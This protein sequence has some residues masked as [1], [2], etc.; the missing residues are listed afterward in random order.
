MTLAAGDGPGSQA[1][2]SQANNVLP[3][4]DQAMFL[5]LRGAGQDSVMQ[6]LWIYDHP[7]DFEVLERFQND[8]GRGWMARL[9]EPSPLP[10]GR[11]RWVSAP[12]PRSDLDVGSPPRA[13]NEFGAWADEQ[14]QLPLDPQSG[15]AWRLGVQ[16]FDDG[17]TAI[18]LV[19]SHCI[20]DG[21]AAIDSI[22]DA[23]NGKVRK[24]DYPP[25]GSRTTVR[26]LREDLLQTVR[27]GGETLRT[28][29]KAL[30]ML[31]RSRR[32]ASRPP[33]EKPLSDKPSRK[34]PAP[35]T[36]G[37]RLSLP[38]VE[39]VV[40]VE[41]WDARA[42][43]LGGNGLSLVAGFAGRLAQHLGRVRTPDGAVTLMIP[44]SE[45]DDIG[46]DTG[47]NVVSI[48]RVS[49]DP[50]PLTTDLSGARAAIRSAVQVARQTP[51][52]M[53][54]LMPL[55]PFVPKR[56]VA[57]MADLAF[58]FSADLPVS[59]SNLGEVPAAM[60]YIDG[61]AAQYLSFRGVD[62]DL[63]RELVERKRGLLTL[64]SGRIEGVVTTTVIGYQPGADNT[65]DALRGLVAQTLEEFNL[66]ATII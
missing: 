37:E 53:V 11:H 54:E 39:F 64:I 50:A 57:G 40:D 9:I 58:G 2:G 20:A 6:F 55:T 41:Q 16:P 42:E 15:P 59:C 47:G 49:I 63:S 36:S 4:P 43:S 28:L 33:S 18:S 30:K 56:A 48:A 46:V 10:F 31:S 22:A 27:D 1:G 14:I 60:N 26:A 66:S 8:F 5:A 61:T 13:R 23:V 7:V 29:G 45:R 52:A 21:R 35:H 24:Q 65:R 32:Q 25:P 19:V 38:T 3:Y 34:P 44:L 12:A 17:S 62:R 51:D